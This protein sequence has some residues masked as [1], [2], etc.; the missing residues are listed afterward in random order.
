M[1]RLTNNWYWVRVQYYVWIAWCVILVSN[2]DVDFVHARN[3]HNS[4]IGCAQHRCHQHPYA[5][6]TL[7][8]FALTHAFAHVFIYETI[9]RHF[10]VGG[11]QYRISASLL[12]LRDA[13]CQSMFSIYTQLIERKPPKALMLCSR[14]LYSISIVTV[15]HQRHTYK[16]SDPF[17]RAR[18][19]WTHIEG[20][21]VKMDQC[22]FSSRWMRWW[23]A[24]N[25]NVPICCCRA[26][27]VIRSLFGFF[28]FAVGGC[29]CVPT[30]LAKSF[31]CFVFRSSRV[32]AVKAMC[33]L[34]STCAVCNIYFR[35]AISFLMIF[36][37]NVYVLFL[38]QIKK[39]WA[40]SQR[41]K[42]EIWTRSRII[43]S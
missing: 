9:F 33:V 15:I 1:I 18:N 17:N 38:L 5:H 30:S 23:W 8:Y 32:S 28:A 13:I 21:C 27:L 2:A 42:E 19:F 12:Y 37:A 29:V 24:D 43:G 14:A 22:A 20:Y 4:E 25:V 26:A 40:I 7:W 3:I 10:S 31:C 11:F 39:T 36:R 6:S 34:S 35:I 41:E 16:N